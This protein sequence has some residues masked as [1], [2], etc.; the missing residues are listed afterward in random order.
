[1]NKTTLPEEAPNTLDVHL[2]AFPVVMIVTGSFY[3]TTLKTQCSLRA[4]LLLREHTLLQIG[5]LLPALII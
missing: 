4:I 5:H 1:M 3:T 2:K